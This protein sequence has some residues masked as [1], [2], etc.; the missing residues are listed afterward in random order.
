MNTINDLI[1]AAKDV[2]QD[3]V[4]LKYVKSD[5][6]DADLLLS[7]WSY[8]SK[9]YDP[10]VDKPGDVN[11]KFVRIWITI[12]NAAINQK[13]IVFMLSLRGINKLIKTD[14]NWNTKINLHGTEYAGFLRFLFE[15]M[16]VKLIREGAGGSGTVY[17]ITN[18]T[19][20]SHITVNVDKQIK[21]SLDFQDDYKSPTKKTAKADPIIILDPKKEDEDIDQELLDLESS[22]IQN[23]IP[24]SIRQ[25]D[26]S[27]AANPAYLM[28]CKGKK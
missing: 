12:C 15:K 10:V 7:H 24:T 6:S 16:G 17:Q 11:L 22:G 13:R 5:F 20:I 8:L 3:T 9:S 21:E 2:T 18:K 4:S 25:P 27:Y 19:V 1:N 14:G 23:E 26:G 28:Q